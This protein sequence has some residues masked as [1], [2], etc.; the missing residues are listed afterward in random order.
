MAR[1]CL[2][3]RPAL[4]GQSSCARHLRKRRSPKI[5]G[6][7]GRE[8][9]AARDVLL[10]TWNAD[11][12]TRCA[13]CGARAR[14]GDPWEP[15]HIVAVVDGGTDDP[16]NLQPEHRYCNRKAG[17]ELAARRRRDMAEHR[18]RLRLLET[19]RYLQDVRR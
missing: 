2:C 8:Y 16:S 10:P 13:R 5:P 6:S 9:E 4:S 7:Y 15:G 12:T 19:A 14:A 18:A 11:P 1:S 3:G 17:A